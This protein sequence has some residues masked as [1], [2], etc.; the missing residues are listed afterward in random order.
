IMFPDAA[1]SLYSELQSGNTLLYGIA[2]LFGADD[3]QAYAA[4]YFSA[5][6]L[7]G[8]FAYRLAVQLGARAVAALVAAAIASLAPAWPM[9]LEHVQVVSLFWALAPLYF[10][11][12]YYELGRRFDLIAFALFA[13]Q[14]FCGP[15]YNLTAFCIVAPCLL[16][17]E[18]PRAMRDGRLRARL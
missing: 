18:A 1:S 14:L 3:A 8:F 9:Q 11:L 5:F 15:S 7:N 12:R 4:I 16:A 17:F 2:R 13:T 6:V 10:A